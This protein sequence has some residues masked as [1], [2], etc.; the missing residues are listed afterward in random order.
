M[1]TIQELKLTEAMHWPE[2]M[3]REGV[4]EVDFFTT[5]VIADANIP[6]VDA[7]FEALYGPNLDP[8]APVDDRYR[9]SFCQVRR[10]PI[11]KH[12]IELGLVL[13]SLLQLIMNINAMSSYLQTFLFA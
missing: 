9:S 2:R 8:R 11:I 7:Q 13:H 6:I 10:H 12:F 4:L 1:I 5:K 3:P